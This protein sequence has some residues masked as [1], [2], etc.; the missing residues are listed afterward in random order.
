MSNFQLW[1]ELGK[2]DTYIQSVCEDEKKGWICNVNFYSYVK[3]DG[4][5]ESEVHSLG[6]RE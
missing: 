4:C 2:Q 3:D 5:R 6:M 1:A